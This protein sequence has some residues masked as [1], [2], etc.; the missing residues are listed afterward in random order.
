M[1]VA[2]E[3]IPGLNR[4][5]D[6]VARERKYLAFLEGPPLESSAAFVRENMS[7]GFPQFVAYRDDQLVGWCDI[8]PHSLPIYAHGGVLGM[9]IVDGHRGLGL[10][11]RLMR[12][13]L[14]AA[15]RFGLSRVELSVW[16]NNAPAIALYQKFGFV[17]EG[18]KRLALKIDGEYCD[19]IMMALLFGESNA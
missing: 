17:T 4:A 15:R 7:K 2:E 18:R 8:V 11:S 10:G 13:T 16:E 9:G 19:S 12:D 14:A 3:C 1:P 5:L 6:L